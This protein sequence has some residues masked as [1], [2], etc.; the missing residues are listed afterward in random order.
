MM[1]FGLFLSWQM[2]QRT[3][4]GLE[5]KGECSLDGT[6]GSQLLGKV[7]RED[8]F[9]QEIFVLQ[10]MRFLHA[11]EPA[12][13]LHTHKQHGLSEDVTQSRVKTCYSSQWG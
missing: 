4:E 1:W 13:I 10:P 6:S 8:S 3:E 5:G 12:V 11:H 2:S 7:F 9:C